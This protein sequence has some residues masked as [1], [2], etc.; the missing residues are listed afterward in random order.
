M[1]KNKPIYHCHI[2]LSTDLD[3]VVL[4]EIARVHSCKVTVIDL[5]TESI[6]QRDVMFTKYDND[7]QKLYDSSIEIISQLKQLN[8]V[9]LKIEQLLVERPL[10]Y[11]STSTDSYMEYHVKVVDNGNLKPV[12]GFVMS[13]NPHESGTRFYNARIYNEDDF[14]IVEN[15]LNN[16]ENIISTH[17]EVSLYDSNRKHDGWW[18]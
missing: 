17:Y 10:A 1:Q 3:L 18:A 5:Y 11:I 12:E 8:P 13:R 6:E 2:T 7:Y 4:K 16:I 14:T 15:S 9:R